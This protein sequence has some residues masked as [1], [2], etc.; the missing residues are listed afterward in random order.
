MPVEFI[1]SVDPVPV[2]VPVLSVPLLIEVPLPVVPVPV[3]PV[4]VEPVPVAV[5]FPYVFPVVLVCPEEFMSEPEPD[6]VPMSEPE[7]DEEPELDPVPE[8]ELDPLEPDVELL[9]VEV[10]DDIRFEE[11]LPEDIPEQFAE[12]V[13]IVPELL[14]TLY[15]Q[16][17][18]PCIANADEWIEPL[19]NRI[20]IFLLES[21]SILVFPEP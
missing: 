5:L 12:N 15:G 3:E 6:P 16:L 17:E 2:P 11:L 1:L 20:I 13:Y 19:S 18:M 9:P 14:L 21:D 8:F 4:P 7:P 10:P